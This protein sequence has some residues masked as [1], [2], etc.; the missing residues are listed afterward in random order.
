MLAQVRTYQV[1]DGDMEE[2]VVL[3]RRHIVPA[4][5]A[6]GFQVLGVWHDLQPL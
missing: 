1:S 3:W 4:R 2:F 5:T 6:H